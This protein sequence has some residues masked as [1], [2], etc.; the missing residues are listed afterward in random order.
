MFG[1]VAASLPTLSEEEKQR[2]RTVYCGLCRS[3]KDRYGQVSRATLN[4]DLTFY[5]LLS[6]S[7]QEPEEVEETGRCFM[8]PVKQT[9]SARSFFSD[10]AADLTVALAYHKC[11]DDW[12]DDR[13]ARA[14]AAERL[15]TGAYKKAQARISDQCLTVE[16]AME[17]IRSIEHDPDASPDAAA[18]SFG[19]MLG[20]LFGY[21]QGIW[22]GQME[23]FGDQLGRFIYM[24][25][26]AVD[27]D[28]DK[29]TGNY[30]PFVRNQTSPEDM[31][32]LLSVLIGRAAD[33]FERLPLEQD[34]HLMRSVLYSG[35]W[36]QFN[37]RYNKAETNASK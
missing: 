35:V 33:T 9:H 21:H 14:K 6:D 10:Y 28:D 19:A 20:S 29:K 32:T 22:T 1:F 5:I 24:M 2:Y 15:L 30:N 7:L 11:L 36:Q 12:E 27:Y 13:K 8:H 31:R 26:A 18:R 25:D 3:L 23:T 17:T 4:F 37:K 34:L 16:H